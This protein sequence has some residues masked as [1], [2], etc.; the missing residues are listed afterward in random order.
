MFTAAALLLLVS[1]PSLAITGA[2]IKQRLDLCGDRH[3]ATN[4]RYRFSRE[5]VLPLVSEFGTPLLGEGE[6]ERDG[7]N[8]RSGSDH[9]G[10]V[11]DMPAD[12]EAQRQMERE[13]LTGDASNGSAG[14]SPVLSP[15]RSPS[16]SETSTA[17][18]TPQG[19]WS[20]RMS[21]GLLYRL[22]DLRLVDIQVKSM[23]RETVPAVEGHERQGSRVRFAEENPMLTGKTNSTDLTE[24][25]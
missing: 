21:I 14:E 11:G 25:P 22:A 12:S 17:S 1:I 2:A 23:P 24:I 9:S 8:K 19:S 20:H 15:H 10:S 6:G 3:D 7:A 5:Q 16:Q 13:R 18:L 4:W